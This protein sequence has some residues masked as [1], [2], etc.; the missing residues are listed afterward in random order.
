M[1][2]KPNTNSPDVEFTPKVVA[3]IVGSM[4]IGAA[5]LAIAIVVFLSA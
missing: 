2:T 1:L 3:P 5:S 4:L